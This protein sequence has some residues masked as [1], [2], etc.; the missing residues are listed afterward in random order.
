[1]PIKIQIT[2]NVS[3]A[4]NFAIFVN[5]STIAPGGELWTDLFPVAWQVAEFGS[6]GSNSP[7]AADLSVK[8]TVGLN[9]IVDGN[10]QRIGNRLPVGEEENNKFIV[11]PDGD[12]YSLFLNKPP[13][14]KRTAEITNNA[15]R[16]V[17]VYYGDENYQPLITSEVGDKTTLAINVMN[18]IAIAAVNNYKVKGIIKS[19]VEGP[20]MKFKLADAQAH[21]HQMLIEYD[22]DKNFK[23]T[24]GCTTPFTQHTSDEN[25]FS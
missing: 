1:M 24:D 14:T 11:K 6:T 17:Y 21:G 15:G 5:P 8:T 13:T 23:W 9:T 10:L 18:E 2:Y 7:F 22:A 3:K 20:W 16:D 12:S 4:Q 25:L 19:E